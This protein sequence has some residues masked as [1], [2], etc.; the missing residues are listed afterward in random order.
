MYIILLTKNVAKTL[1]K[2]LHFKLA[3]YRNPLIQDLSSH[4]IP[5][6][7]S[8]KSVHLLKIES[9]LINFNVLLVN[10]TFYSPQICLLLNTSTNLKIENYI[11][12]KNYMYT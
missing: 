8:I 9:Q 3:N 4:N 12:K 1:F 2:N 6:L 5:R 7:P 11:K 10:N